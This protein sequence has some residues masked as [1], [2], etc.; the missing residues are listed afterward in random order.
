MKRKIY[1]DGELGEKFGKVLVLD[2]DNFLEVFKAIDCQRPELRPYLVECH[3]KNIGFVMH[4]ED[5]PITTEEEVLINF[6]EG[7]MYISPA[8]EGSGGVLRGIAK[9]VV[10]AIMIIGGL[11]LL[12]GGFYIM[13]T[14]ALAAGG[15]FLS[16]GLMDLLAPDPSVDT[17]D[18]RQ[19]AS[20]L[21]Q[22]AGQTILNGDPVPLLYGRLRIP[23]RLVDFDV[24]NSN[25]Y[26]SELGYG[27]SGTGTR[28]QTPNPSTDP[29]SGP[30]HLPPD[31]LPLQ[32]IIPTMPGQTEQI[33][34]G[35]LTSPSITFDPSSQ[36]Y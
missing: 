34:F 5:T 33:N 19:D 18:S 20:Y 23:G 13:G 24:R 4:I 29:P 26:Y 28:I 16:S 25:S 10:G 11:A 36:V 9:V 30:S 22:G 2:V 27:I 35:T 12:A 3:E 7:D 17:D 21:F 8:P 6:Q 15:A 31:P 32:P 1:L 14:L